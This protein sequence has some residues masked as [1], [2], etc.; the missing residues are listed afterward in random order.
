MAN[1]VFLSSVLRRLYF[2]QSVNSNIESP[3]I[4]SKSTTFFKNNQVEEFKEA[5]EKQ[6]SKINF[7]PRVDDS[8]M[9][10]DI[11]LVV[12]DLNNQN[13]LHK[14]QSI[15]ITAQLKSILSNRRKY[16]AS[17]CH[18]VLTLIPTCVWRNS[19]FIRK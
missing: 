2:T 19:L 1:E 13:I 15:S 18:K 10:S 6:D 9:S 12:N 14:D 3:F 17:G 7:N 16:K 4:I 11:N 5:K 8:R